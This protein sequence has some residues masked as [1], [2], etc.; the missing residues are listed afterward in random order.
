M[1]GFFESTLP[2]LTDLPFSFIGCEWPEGQ[3]G[4]SAQL[5]EAAAGAAEIS[6]GRAAA[7]QA[8]ARGRWWLHQGGQ[9]DS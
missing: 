5:P 2:T 3:C 1:R 9:K 6:Q 4:G 7:V 8:A